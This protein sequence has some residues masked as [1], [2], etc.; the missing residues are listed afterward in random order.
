M[1]KGKVAVFMCCYNSEKFV[2]EA[3]ETIINQTYSNWEL[4]V[5]NDGSKD[6]SAKIISSYKD[7]RIH[8]YDFKENTRL[9]GVQSL[10]EKKVMESD[11]E[12][13]VETA[14]DDKW[15]LDKLERQ[16][17]VLDNHPEYGACFSWDRVIFEDGEKNDGDSD[18]YAYSHVTNRSRHAW[19]EKVLL[20]ANCFNTCSALIRKDVYYKMGGYNQYYIRLGDYRLWINILLN[21]PI[22]MIEEPLVYY[23]RHSN[24]L[25]H[26]S[27]YTA[28]ATN[29]EAYNIRRY[30]H[31]T[32]SKKD[33]FYIFYNHLI[34]D[35]KT[36]EDFEADKVFLYIC[37]ETT[38][39]IINDQLGIEKWLECSD[40]PKIM[41]DLEKKYGFDIFFLEKFKE[42]CG[43]TTLVSNAIE[44]LKDMFSFE[45]PTLEE[46]FVN[47]YTKRIFGKDEI[48][49]YTCNPFYSFA[50]YV[51]KN[52]SG[53]K[54][55]EMM[56]EKIYALRKELLEEK[57]DKVM[58]II[59]NKDTR[60]DIDSIVKKYRE[61]YRIYISFVKKTDEYYLKTDCDER[62]VQGAECVDLY[63][64]KDHSLYFGFDRGIYADVIYYIDC[65][66]DDYQCTR[67]IRGYNLG[68]T[69]MALLDKPK[70]KDDVDLEATI[71]TIANVEIN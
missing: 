9:V 41:G 69:Q 47:Q 62:S 50:Y 18:E 67:M 36:K 4:W 65:L 12:Y 29:N 26:E 66:G 25:S 13:M 46:I 57:R 17:A 11:C 64:I 42:N 52:G 5:A 53:S 22:Y 14:S 20:N 23:R 56:K 43:I 54:F 38:C 27:I 3:I 15:T 33:F 28:M 16:V 32:L 24:N 60:V 8:F 37:A 30:V 59:C 1:K 7:D 31:S 2:A 49:R 58:H 10:L 61:E 48:V 39:E 40:N 34:Y 35:I 45:K 70:F 55:F 71:A 19:L 68:I 6:S 51:I 44:P 21:Y 63:S